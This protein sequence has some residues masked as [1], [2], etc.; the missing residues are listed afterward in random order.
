MKVSRN[1]SLLYDAGEVYSVQLD[2]L[3]AD[4]PGGITSFG[5]PP[6]GYS[7]PT[8]S[9][10]GTR[11]AV[12]IMAPEGRDVWVYDLESATPQRL[13]FDPAP[14]IL[15]IWTPDG[16]RIVFESLR[17]GVGLYWK[18]ADGSGPAERLTTS[19]TRQI[20]YAWSKDGSKLLFGEL[21]PETGWDIKA[22][23]WDEPTSIET[24]IQTAAS[25]FNAA[26]SPDGR[27]LAYQSDE[28]GLDEIYVQDFPALSGKWQVSRGGGQWPMWDPAGTELYYRQDERMLSVAV[29]MSGGLSL[30]SP[31]ELF[32]VAGFVWSGGSLEGVGRTYAV[33]PRGERFLIVRDELASYEPAQTN[34]LIIVLNWYEE[35]KQLV[36]TDN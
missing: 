3:W 5:A 15:P 26:M 7:A 36:P 12:H 19:R 33:G 27:W 17:D 13:T 22:L 29:D 32:H 25:E 1:G 21:D 6:Q 2:L 20:P 24:L 11:V 34:E 10:D 8:L 35:L 9:P 4:R 30:E 23:R 16:E 18:A 31:R 28:S 14:D